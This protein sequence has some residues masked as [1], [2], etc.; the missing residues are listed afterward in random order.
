[1]SK[2]YFEDLN[3]LT[4][5]KEKVVTNVLRH[6]ENQSTK[7]DKFKWGYSILTLIV[8]GCMFLFIFT[9]IINNPKH[10]ASEVPILKK[11]I[12]D[13]NIKSQLHDRT[14]TV[15]EGKFKAF[16]DTLQL[17]ANYAYALSKGIILTKKEINKKEEE[18]LGNLQELKQDQK[19]REEFKELLGVLK[20]SE[21]QLI[22]QYL[23]PQAIKTV[24][25]D[26]LVS[27]YYQ[28]HKDAYELHV[29]TSLEQDAMNYL[30]KK[31]PKKIEKL[32][33][34]YNVPLKTKEIGNLLKIGMVVAIEDDKFLVVNRAS[35]KELGQLS[36]SQIMK[37]HNNG[38]WFPMHNVT[39]KIKTGDKVQISYNRIQDTFPEVANLINIKILN[40]K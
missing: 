38:T 26:R 31:Y 22:D 11:D 33:K 28:Q 30:I 14:L 8:T 29:M 32:Q 20:L 13:I 1:M 21:Q 3:N 39:K 5:S 34:V 18:I 37:K 10:T 4:K 15:E 16:D 27:D 25:F 2:T 19:K 6:I 24:A 35:A 12:Y 7:K 17:D 23:K 36:A 9:Q 40:N